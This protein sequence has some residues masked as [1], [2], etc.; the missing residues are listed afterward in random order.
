MSDNGSANGGNS[1]NASR[2]EKSLGL[3]TTRF[4]SLLQDAKDGVLDLKVVC[5]QPSYYPCMIHQLFLPFGISL[6]IFTFEPL[7][8]LF[9]YFSLSPSPFL[10]I[11]AFLHF[12]CF[13]LSLSLSLY[14]RPCAA[15]VL[16]LLTLYLY[17]QSTICTFSF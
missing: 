6:T 10:S 15:P 1:N 9:F 16:F 7:N 12:T 17:T 3:L 5:P 8:C 13:S 4:V 11:F 2:H 14:R